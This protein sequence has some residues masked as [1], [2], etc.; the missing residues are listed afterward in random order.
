ML[1]DL[2]LKQLEKQLRYLKKE[3][4]ALIKANR[5]AAITAQ[6]ALLQGRIRDLEGKIKRRKVEGS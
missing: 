1:V 4:M 3:K 2:K 6:L 5:R